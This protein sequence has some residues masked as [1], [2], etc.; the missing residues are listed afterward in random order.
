MRAGSL[1]VTF[2]VVGFCGAF[3]LEANVAMA[4]VEYVINLEDS[5]W[6][7]PDG[8]PSTPPGKYFDFE[9]APDGIIEK[10]ELV[11][12][13]RHAY[14][15]DLEAWLYSPDDGIKLFSGLSAFGADFY[16]TLFRDDE[17]GEPAPIDIGSGSPPYNRP[18][19]GYYVQDVG[20]L[21]AFEGENAYSPGT[22][23]RLHIID[24]YA[25]DEGYVVPF[26]NAEPPDDYGPWVGTQLIITIVPE[27]ASALLVLLAAPAVL[28]R[29]MRRRR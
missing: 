24:H 9:E 2:L 19:G 12:S 18:N 27:P 1:V 28:R 7:I 21:A 14:D 20:G 22:P 3:V 17:P 13:V 5:D 26:G 15:P 6:S 8:P 16:D 23:W 29:R 11:F 4:S 10:V 25:G